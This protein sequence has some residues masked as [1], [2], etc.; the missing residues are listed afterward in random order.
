MELEFLTKDGKGIFA[1][2]GSI[3]ALT[4]AQLTDLINEKLA[5]G[6]TELVIDLNQVEFLSSAGL[7]AILGALKESRQRGGDLHLAAAQPG[8]EKVLKISGFTS[9]LKF[10]PNRQEALAGFSG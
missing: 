5:E 10:Y 6:H 7:R 9:I 4:S 1:V 3:D 2:N 8:V